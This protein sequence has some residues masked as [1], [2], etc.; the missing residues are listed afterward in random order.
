MNT[1]EIIKNLHKLENISEKDKNIILKACEKLA[2]LQNK[3]N[4]SQYD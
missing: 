3:L 1:Q 4:R 2:Y